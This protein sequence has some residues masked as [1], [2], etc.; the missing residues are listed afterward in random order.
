[1]SRGIFPDSVGF[2]KNYPVS[3][4]LAGIF[5][6]EYRGQIFKLIYANLGLRTN[7]ETNSDAS[8]HYRDFL[9]GKIECRLDPDSG[10]FSN[11]L[12]WQDVVGAK[13]KEN[14]CARNYRVLAAG[15]VH[16]R[17]ADIEN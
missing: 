15:E 7:I 11:Q 12:E 5:Y 17:R 13:N 1:M 8:F 14:I 9:F 2:K 6:R 16:R 3:N 4:E 10:C